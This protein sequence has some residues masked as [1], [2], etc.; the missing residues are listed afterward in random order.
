[1]GG[2]VKEGFGW[3]IKENTVAGIENKREAEVKTITSH[4]NSQRS[5]QTYDEEK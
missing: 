1:M 2:F 3:R 4:W 5:I